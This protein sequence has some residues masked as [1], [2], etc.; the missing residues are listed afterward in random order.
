MDLIWPQV[1]RGHLFQR[2]DL[3]LQ[4]VTDDS[5]GPFFGTGRFFLTV[6][7]G[8]V[9]HHDYFVAIL[10]GVR[11]GPEHSIIGGCPGNDHHV[12]SHGSQCVVKV[13][14]REAA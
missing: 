1:S 12:A 7:H 13:V 5:Q 11:R 14:V 3:S 2:R 4:D 10:M 9:L 6:D 8:T